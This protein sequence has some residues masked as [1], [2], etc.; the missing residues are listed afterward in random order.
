MISLD[1]DTS[2]DAALLARFANE[3]GFSW[4]FALASNEI[5]TQLAAAFG[6][7]FLTQPSEPMFLVDPRGA[8]HA[9][10]F[11]HKSA[12]QLRGS[13]QQFRA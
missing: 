1:T 5:L 13:I 12:D 8:T 10:P 11:G 7:E 4:R 2:E 3:M 6:T 9:L